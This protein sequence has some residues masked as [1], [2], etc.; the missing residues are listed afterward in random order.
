MIELL[1][2]PDK[3]RVIADGN[4]TDILLQARQDPNYFVRVNI[5]IDD[6]PEP[7]LQQ[8]W[9]KDENGFC[10]FN[11]KHLYYSYFQNETT[12]DYTT[13]FHK[14]DG[15]LKKVQIVAEEY[16]IGETV[17]ESF[18]ELPVFF[19]IKNQRPVQFDDETEL[20]FLGL[21]QE[22]IKVD[23][24]AG[25][26]F[27]L[28]IRSGQIL[29]VSVQDELNQEIHSETLVNYSLQVTQYELNFADLEITGLKFIY[30]KFSTSSAAIQKK[31]V[32][33]DKTF[34]PPK[35]IFYLNNYGFYI[36]ACLFGRKEDDSSLSPKSYMQKD[37]TRVTY[38]VEDTKELELYSGY[39]YK[40]IA[41]LIHAVAISTDV[42]M[43]L[44]GNWERV[45]SATKK[46]V[47]EI[48]NQFIYGDA[49]KF[50]RVNV[51][52]FT[53]KNTYAMVPEIRN[54]TASG[55][56]NTII[57][58]SK[59]AFITIYTAIQPAT[60][61]QIREVPENGKISF[62]D[63]N[64]TI[65]LSDLIANNPQLL[66]YSIPLAGLVKL[67][68]EPNQR[69]DGTPLDVLDFKMGTEVI[70]S[71]TAQIIYNVNDIPETDLPPEIVVNTIKYIPLDVNNDGSSQIDTTINLAEGHGLEILWEAL[72]GAPIT[73][74]DN[75]LEDPVI[76]LTDA[77]PNS[78]YQVRVTTTDTTNGLSSSKI[79]NINTS[80]FSVKI[81]KI[82]YPEQLQS[83][84]V[85]LH[86]S[87]GQ[88][89]GQFTLKLTVLMYQ[90]VY[91]GARYVLYNYNLPNEE[92]KYSGSENLDLVLDGNGELTIPCQIVN[93]AASEITLEAE[94][95]DVVLPQIIDPVNFKVTEK[96][97][98]TE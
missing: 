80:S 42:R 12:C 21:P 64:G 14:K 82:S 24:S 1:Q 61:L 5:F 38:D 90:I 68:Y 40:S 83:E 86:I 59:A 44:D 33:G 58:I 46:V 97:T 78:T 35:T 76:T 8:G 2:S 93:G 84:Q 81:E 49:L 32:F 20:Q 22:N 4:D 65:E 54:I 23:R 6:D 69:K 51:P 92:I 75:T 9:S 3:N 72:N 60:V 31:L 28:F 15:L 94:I 37:G 13:G 26:I 79:I 39:G 36:S 47:H 30:V 73:F 50:E 7:F 74:D 95:V 25:F 11:I 62:V 85:D 57:E 71:N 66:P 19:L 98:G 53:N 45:E 43:L 88:P 27:P 96:F 55:D 48:D 70:L 63:A 34:F 17:R 77:V 52:S 29:T 87:G 41:A 89:N 91:G 67:L 10:E 56:E 16:K 18:L